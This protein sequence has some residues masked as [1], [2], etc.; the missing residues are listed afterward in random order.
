MPI[1][2]SPL[3][4]QSSSV[5]SALG[6]AAKD[7]LISAGSNILGGALGGIDPSLARLNVAGLASGGLKGLA[8]AAVNVLFNNNADH[9]WRVRVSLPAGANYFYNDTSNQILA[10]LTKATFN[11]GVIFPYTP[12]V[13]V[14]HLANYNQQKLTHANYAAYF[15]ENSEVQEINITGDF[16][17]QSIDEGQYLMAA[18]HF[19]RSATKM[20]YGKDTNPIAGNPPPVLFL[21]GYG[22]N[23]FPHVPCVLKSFTHTMP[24]DI[25]YVDVPA[26]G[27]PF[28]PMVMRGPKSTRLPTNSQISITLQPIFSRLDQTQNF[29]L[30]D[31]AAGKLVGKN[32]G[33]GA[34]DKGGFI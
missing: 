5:G 13:T 26:Y 14:T 17:V 28:A 11:V 22:T 7:T 15:Y 27:N 18:I 23:Y 4:G 25:D 33:L 6:A 1:G 20:F 32:G 34:K 21:D 24:A 8:N 3:S 12:T 30:K 10:P 9:D 31:F 16:S 29:S 19:F 2:P